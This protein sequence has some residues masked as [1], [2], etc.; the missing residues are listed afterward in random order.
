MPL[1]P[2]LEDAGQERKF[3]L[4][5]GTARAVWAV[6]S[7]NLTTVDELAAPLLT[8]VRTTYYD[9][10][11]LAYFRSS[12]GPVARRLRVRE[13]A[14]PDGEELPTPEVCY[15]EL[16]QSAGGRRA[17]TRVALR[18]DEVA[19]QLEGFPEPLAPYVA[20]L[21]RRRALTDERVRVTLDD[22]LLFCRPRPL[23]S[24]FSDLAVDDVIA[25]CPALVLEVKLAGDPPSWLARILDLLSEAI[26]FS[27]FMF[28]MELSLQALRFEAADGGGSGS[29]LAF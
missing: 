28:G 9:T 21:Y 4:Q 11:D 25:R 15:L 14:C 7:G 10:P 3:V 20:S 8:Y 22:G 1:S 27:K 5:P 26:G 18:P 13:Y 6:A 12:S 24:P 23:G 29:P 2:V 16:K 17:K 19:A